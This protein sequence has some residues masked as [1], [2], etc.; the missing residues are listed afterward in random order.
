MSGAGSVIL[1]A[2]GFIGTR[3]VRHRREHLDSVTALD[4]VP[5]RVRLDG[6]KYLDAD[7]R[8]PIDPALGAGASILYNLAAVHRTPGHPDYEY[9]ETNIPGALNATA[10]AEACDI[11]T[12]VFTSSI[13]VYGPCEQAVTEDSPLRPVSAYGRSKRLAERI[14]RDWLARGEGR[15]LI[16]ARPGVVF[17]PG[18]VGNYTRLARGLRGG[19]F[20]F[21]GR[22]D[23]V[24]SGGFVDELLSTFDFALGRNEASIL[25]NF[26]YPEPSTTEEIVDILGP[27]VGRRSRPLTLPIAPL[28]AAALM[29]E[30]ANAVG[31]KNTIHRDRVMKL[32][33]STRITP[34]WL[35][36]SGYQF[37]TNL[38]AALTRWRDETDGRF[39]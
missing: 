1:G 27:I 18:E 3:L 5:P 30:A 39:D 21:P 26:A 12:I 22:R 23:T 6:V 25:Y 24:K 19:Y 36:S 16:I 32:V 8:E 4:I 9:Y 7:V 17:G 38:E 14:H 11:R 10:F 33:Q 2:S 28:M 20:V 15:R 37:S 13:S 35:T 34:A 31:I 29:F